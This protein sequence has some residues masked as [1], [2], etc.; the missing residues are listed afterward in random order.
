MKK[1]IAFPTALVSGLACVLA[2]WAG[3]PGSDAVDRRLSAGATAPEFTLGD[4]DGTSHTLSKYTS[5]GKVVVLEWFNP[6]SA[7]SIRHHK[8][9][10]TLDGLAARYAD[11]DVAWLAINSAGIWQPGFGVDRNRQAIEELGISYPVLLDTEG[12]VAGSYMAQTTPHM[13]VIDRDG[14]VAYS[15]AIDDAPPA[16]DGAQP[17]PMVNYVERALDALLTHQPITTPWVNPYGERVRPSPE[18]GVDPDPNAE[19]EG[20][21]PLLPPS[22]K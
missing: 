16:D 6:E 8:D 15:G 21:P 17:T 20:D 13:Y 5:E 14:K 9:L 19:P 3:G 22:E 4:V 1:S 12:S 10:H 11:R 18:P 2:V 7:Q